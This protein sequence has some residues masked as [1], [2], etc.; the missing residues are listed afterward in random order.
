MVEVM[1][2]GEEDP[3]LVS[4]VD[5]L[6]MYQVFIWKYKWFIHTST[7]PSMWPKIVLNC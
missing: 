6:V 2:E 7:V 4:I 5:K 3:P 1:M